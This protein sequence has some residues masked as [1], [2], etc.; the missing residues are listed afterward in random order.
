MKRNLFA[1]QVKS[2]GFGLS[3]FTEDELEQIHYATLEVL[4]KTGLYIG[5]PEALQILGDS[6]A[7]VDA[8]NRIV[9]FP[10]YL[11]EN[12]IASAPPTVLL[13]G[14]EEKHD[15]VL[16]GSRVGFTAFGEGII[17]VDPNTGER[18]KPKKAD[19]ATSAVLLDYLSEIDVNKKVIGAHDVPQ[20][21]ALIHIAEVLF[22]NT[23]K[24]CFMGADDGKMVKKIVDMGVAIS[25]SRS[26]LRERPLISFTTCPVSPLQ[27]IKESCE[28]IME[29]AK[30]GMMVNVLSM[31]MAGG[32]SPISLA[33]TLV[34]HNAEVLGGLVLHQCTNKGAPFMYGS[35]TTAMD[36]RLAAAAVGSPECGMINAAVA[37]LANYYGLPSWVAGG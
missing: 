21:S 7:I 30:S 15:V 31:A 37:R 4:K 11:L 24:H 12:S 14:R 10:A 18:R 34:I 28:I 35:S 5:D 25:G 26:R 20:E 22:Q 27:L 13:A 32:S 9:K 33:G 1:G 29:S 6:G 23:T 17:L 36:M 3:L 8:K 2:G 16:G 19:T